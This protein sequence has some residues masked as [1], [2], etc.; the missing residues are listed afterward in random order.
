[1]YCFFLTIF[2]EL[3]CLRTPHDFF[4]Y[5]F[6]RIFHRERLLALKPFGKEIDH[7]IPILT[8][9]DSVVNPDA[10]YQAVHKHPGKNHSV[11]NAVTIAAQ[12]YNG[13]LA[14]AGEFDERV[15]H[16]HGIGERFQSFRTNAT[17]KG[18][19]LEWERSNRSNDDL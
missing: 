7:K 3:F 2:A 1:M 6:S 19:L 5:G 8:P 15:G 4:R 13:G 16:F 12:G 14:R 18:I 9:Q 11:N 17:H 10:L